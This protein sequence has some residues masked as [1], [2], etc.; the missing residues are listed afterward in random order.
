MARKN[1]P[2]LIGTPVEEGARFELGETVSLAVRSSE[3]DIAVHVYSQPRFF[4]ELFSRV[5]LARGITRLL[6]SLSRFFSG[7]Q[8]SSLMHPQL[9]VRG[10]A[11]MRK[12]AR[13]F[14]TTP[15]VISAMITALLA[16]IALLSGLWLLPW[17]VERLLNAFGGVPYLAVNLVACAFRIAGLYLSVAVCA[18]MKL[19]N[20]LSMYRGAIAKVTNAYEIYGANP[21]EAEVR[22]SP[23]LTERSDGAFLL[24]ALSLMMIGCAL[25]RVDSAWLAILV[26]LGMLFAGAAIADECILPIEN[27]RADSI[28]A[29]LRR[30]YAR[31]QLLF[32]LDAHPQMLEVALCALR[33]AID[34]DVSDEID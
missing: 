24:I 6:A 31:L 22:R 13:L 33:A 32:T 7:L 28:L 23:E 25:V 5:P 14:Q 8:Y 15:Q 3:R 11:K 10:G 4:R 17:L 20:R 2:R 34:N 16:P 9:S 27:A 30:R 19:L 26:R 21:T 18:R 1:S 12:T 29:H